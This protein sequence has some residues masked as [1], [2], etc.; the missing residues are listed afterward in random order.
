MDASKG[1]LGIEDMRGCY[2]ILYTKTF[3]VNDSEQLR[4]RFIACDKL[5][6]LRIQFTPQ[7]VPAKHPPIDIYGDEAEDE[8]VINFKGWNANLTY[9]IDSP[10]ELIKIGN[11]RVLFSVVN[12][13]MGTSNYFT[14]Q[15]YQDTT[16]Q[17]FENG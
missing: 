8:T 1:I 15:V 2:Q 5:V 3:L 16:Q 11:K 17:M 4:W 6:K 14:I 12:M 13:H 10:V 9:H 7:S